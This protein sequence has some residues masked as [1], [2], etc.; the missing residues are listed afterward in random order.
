[1]ADGVLRVTCGPL[2]LGIRLDEIHGVRTSRSL[3]ASP[4]LS[5]QRIEITYG[6]GRRIL[7]SPEDRDGFL[8]AIGQTIAPA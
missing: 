2:R 3:L 4:A 5:L 8:D 6:N 7:L 1:V